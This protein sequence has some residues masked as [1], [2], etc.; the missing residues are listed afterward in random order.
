MKVIKVYNE[1]FGSIS[2]VIF[3]VSTPKMNHILLVYMYPY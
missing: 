2:I 3:I 1:I